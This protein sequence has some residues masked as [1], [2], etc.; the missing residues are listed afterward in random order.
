MTAFAISSD[1][2]CDVGTVSLSVD[3]T[4]TGVGWPAIA[5]MTL[6]VAVLTIDPASMSA[7][8]AV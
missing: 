8:V 3:V 4:V 6:A 1:G 7:C 5:W 2:V